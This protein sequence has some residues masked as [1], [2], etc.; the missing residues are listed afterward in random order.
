MLCEGASTAAMQGVMLMPPPP[1]HTLPT[2]HTLPPLQGHLPC[3]PASLPLLHR[4]CCCRQLWRRPQQQQQQVLLLPAVPSH[5]VQPHG[6]R[7]LGR[8]AANP[9][10]RDCAGSQRIPLLATAL[11]YACSG[12][13]FQHALHHPASYTPSA[14]PGPPPQLGSSNPSHKRLSL[15]A[16]AT[17]HLSEGSVSSLAA[18]L[19]S[20]CHAQ[21]TL[22]PSLSFSAARAWRQ[23]PSAGLLWSQ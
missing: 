3:L 9:Q 13:Q 8:T 4:L 14:A 23:Q 5:P 12:G 17:N 22:H 10:G 18:C 16:Q 11:S 2:A 20:P 21:D 7:R 6:R 19:H 1:L 15:G